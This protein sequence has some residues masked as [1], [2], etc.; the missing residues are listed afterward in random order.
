[1]KNIVT[2]AQDVSRKAGY[3]LMAG[4]VV[5][6]LAIAFIFFRPVTNQSRTPHLNVQI[7]PDE[8]VNKGISVSEALSRPLFWVER[9][10]DEQAKQEI[11]VRPVESIQP[12]SGIRLVGIIANDLSHVALFEVDGKT[13]RIKQGERVQQWTVSEVLENEVRLTSGTERTTLIIEREPHTN[14]R[15]EHQP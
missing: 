5:C 14:I 15:L 9:R 1:M 13:A 7:L 2:R 10:P 3:F 11:D 12:L 4:L 8:Q 6:M